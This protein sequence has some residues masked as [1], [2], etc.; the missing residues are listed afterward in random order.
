MGKMSLLHHSVTYS[1]QAVQKKDF[2]EYSYIPDPADNLIRDNKFK[3]RL[4]LDYHFVYQVIAA[5]IDYIQ[6][7]YPSR[8]SATI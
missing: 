5:T 4:H 6:S 2:H 8:L 1:F 7:T 3:F